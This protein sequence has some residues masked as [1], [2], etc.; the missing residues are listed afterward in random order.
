MVFACEGNKEMETVEVGKLDP[1]TGKKES[2][3]KVEAVPLYLAG[4]PNGT[5]LAVLRVKGDAG[6][7]V[8][9]LFDEKGADLK[10]IP[11]PGGKRN[12]GHL[13]WEGGNIWVTTCQDDKI[14]LIRVEVAT[15]KAQLVPLSPDKGGK[16][17]LG[18]IRP[19]LSPDGKKLAVNTCLLRTDSDSPLVPLN[20]IDLAA[21]DKAPEMI[22]LSDRK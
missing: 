16:D 17:A 9:H 6:T 14:G 10:D 22:E 1:E 8:L 15:G 21:P 3:A 4:D 12:I 19:S 18:W 11:L 7:L 5:G 2:L 20:I 13:V